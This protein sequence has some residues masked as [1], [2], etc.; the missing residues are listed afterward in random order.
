[1]AGM[2]FKVALFTLV[3][4]TT[5]TMSSTSTSLLR[6]S[7]SLTGTEELTK[8]VR[9]E[10]PQSVQDSVDYAFA[11]LQRSPVY[12]KQDGSLGLYSI[13]GIK[14]EALVSWMVKK[15]PE[16]KEFWLMDVGAAGGKWAKEMAECLKKLDTTSPHFNIVSLSGRDELEK[17]TIKYS[18]NITIHQLPNFALENIAK[19]FPLKVEGGFDL[20]V[21]RWTLCHLVDPVGTLAQLYEL[22]EPT[23][24]AFLL[25]DSFF[26]VIDG[27]RKKFSVN[28][29]FT[30][31]GIGAYHTD[32]YELVISR[33]TKDGLMPSL[34]YTGSVENLKYYI[35]DAYSMMST[36]FRSTKPH[37]IVDWMLSSSKQPLLYGYRQRAGN[38]AALAIHETMIKEGLYTYDPNFQKY[39]PIECDDLECSL[40]CGNVDKIKEFLE[41]DP[42]AIFKKTEVDFKRTILDVSITKMDY[43]KYLSIL[44][45]NPSKAEAIRKYRNQYDRT[46][47]YE[48]VR[49]PSKHSAL[50]TLLDSGI[51]KKDDVAEKNVEKGSSKRF[52]A[53]YFAMLT[54]DK[55]KIDLLIPK[56]A[57]TDI[58]EC[59][60]EMDEDRN[61]LKACKSIEKINVLDKDKP[62]FWRENDK[63]KKR[64]IEQIDEI[65]T[66][67]LRIVFKRHAW[68]F[69]VLIDLKE[70]ASVKRLPDYT[71]TQESWYKF[72]RDSRAVIIFT[73]E[74]LRILKNMECYDKDVM[75]NIFLEFTDL[76]KETLDAILE[77]ITEKGFEFPKLV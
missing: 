5:G 49:T 71:K 21:A 26:V 59:L 63:L 14:E 69:D 1:M 74:F 67:S 68:L 75:K 31:P 72:Q 3:S 37:D 53:L 33:G 61:L 24:T 52:S 38:G 6:T 9:F 39:K 22:L 56:T 42:D 47:I 16:K 19:I 27:K 77:I 34:E 15:K 10:R 4:C 30:T 41:K 20:I 7:P 62:K 66:L 70:K 76:T 29:L 58:R 65:I 54:T 13:A 48:C 45:S 12:W 25:T 11:A 46:L 35:T 8:T 23:H 18:D 40:Y 17:A 43:Y 32:E 60:Q 36:Q 44:I 50:K 51:F 73:D 64:Y 28:H 55:E 57:V 2:F